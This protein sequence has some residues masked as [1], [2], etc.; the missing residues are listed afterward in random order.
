MILFCI[1]ITA[2]AQTV[3]YEGRIKP[4]LQTHC[5]NCHNKASIGPMPLTTYREVKAYGKMV[6]YVTE[7]RIMPPWKADAGF[8]PLK[9]VHPLDEPSVAAIKNWVESG[10]SQGERADTITFPVATTV[11]IPKPD[12]ILAM[13]KPFSLTDD[14]TERSQVFVLPF[15][16]KKAEW[17]DAIEFVP[18]NRRLVKSCTVSVDTGQTGT[19]YDSND[20]TYGYGSATSVGFIPYQLAW[21]Q[22]TADEG[23]TFYSSPYAK[24]LPAA[25]KILL[26]ITYA[27]SKT[28]QKDSSYLK[29]RFAKKDSG[30]RAIRSQLLLDTSHISNGPF[31][32][33]VGDKRKFYAANK[34]DTAIEIFSVMP[35]GQVALSSWEIY[36][37]DSVSDRRINLLKISH[38]EPHWK[39]K[40]LLEAPVQLSAGS[41]IFGV[42]YYNNSD[43]NPNLPIL[44]PQK[45]KYGEGKRDEFFA[46][47]FDVVYS[48]A[49]A[50]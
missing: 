14:Y 1:E 47:L 25:S 37:V 45:I 2:P 41:K 32:I 24:M 50:H 4:I 49:K 40:Y 48:K 8:S 17:I 11:A 3:D 26:H 29:L 35:M 21:Y 42:A 30:L 22:W 33:N 20:R 28:V 36:A 39:K 13:E 18:G 27:A 15:N 23:A 16:A 19:Q 43:D 7:N 6:Q 44:P 38:W 34:F 9:N 10:M 12:L 46:V 31:R 5:T